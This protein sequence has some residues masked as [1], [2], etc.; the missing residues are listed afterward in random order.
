MITDGPQGFIDAEGNRT[1][2]ATALL[3]AFQKLPAGEQCIIGHEQLVLLCHELGHGI[4]DLVAKTTYAR[5]HG[6]STAADFNEAP[7]QLLENWCWQP[8]TLALLVDNVSESS[9]SDLLQ[10]KKT[11]DIIKCLALLEISLFDLRANS[12]STTREAEDVD[13]EELH[14]DVF[15]RVWGFDHDPKCPTIHAAE[16]SHF[17]VSGMYIYL[18]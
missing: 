11:R 3:C 8:V 12:V 2:A 13:T 1:P 16:P 7:S 5:F 17:L 9:V 10:G 6:A 4:H 18:M 14:R 15:K